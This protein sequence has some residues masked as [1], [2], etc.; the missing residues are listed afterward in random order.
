MPDDVLDTS[1]DSGSLAVM[2]SASSCNVNK[3]YPGPA[4]EDPNYIAPTPKPS[5]LPPDAQDVEYSSVDD[6][7]VKEHHDV[8]T[9]ASANDIISEH[10]AHHSSRPPNIARLISSCDSLECSPL[11]LECIYRGPGPFQCLLPGNAGAEEYADASY[12]TLDAI[13]RQYKGQITS[14][15]FDAS[16]LP[17]PNDPAEKTYPI[18][19]PL[20]RSAVT[21]GE[22]ADD[23]PGPAFVMPELLSLKIHTSRRISLRS[24]FQFLQCT[25]VLQT[26]SI[27]AATLHCP[28]IYA[29]T[30]EDLPK[31]SLPYM[32]QVDLQGFFADTADQL[33]SKL[34][35]NAGTHANI[36]LNPGFPSQHI[37]GL[38][39]MLSRVRYACLSYTALERGRDAGSRD[40]YVFSF[41][42]VDARVAVHWDWDMA[43][44]DPAS[45]FLVTLDPG[46]AALARV[47]TLTVAVRGVALPSFSDWYTVLRPFPSLR[48]LD[49]HV[50][51]RPGQ[52]PD[53]ADPLACDVRTATFRLRGAALLGRVANVPLV[54]ALGLAEYCHPEGAFPGGVPV[55]FGPFKWLYSFTW[56]CMVRQLAE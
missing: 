11:R 15:V 46:G 6:H 36:H 39:P 40:R 54:F 38:R 27:H 28:P 42:D 14:M 20:T 48:H 21:H 55:I 44:G 22:H 30:C 17:N 50:T 10:P 47:H 2:G 1:L 32:Q 3:D 45:L 37:S 56:R 13:L 33:L 51:P 52:G 24:L 7:T 5:S 43:A 35:M 18:H 53:A 31:V 19:L 49:L 29:E 34:V 12:A 25:P 9:A 4:T 8:N 16:S 41:S 23:H 26:L